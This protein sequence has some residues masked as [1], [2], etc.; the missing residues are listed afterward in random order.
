ML[1]LADIPPGLIDEAA[2]RL[3]DLL[4][5]TP[6]LPFPAWSE[7]GGGSISL[8]LETLQPIGSFKVRGALNAVAALSDAQR[9]SGVYT[10]SAGN[11][12]QALAFAAARVDST[13]AVVVPETAPAAKLDAAARLG[14]DIVSVP[15]D[16]WWDVIV[17]GRY[18]PLGLRAWV[19]PFADPRVI[20]GHG[21]IGLELIEQTPE[22]ACVYVPFGGGGL[23][24]GIALA[25]REHAPHVEV[26]ASEVDTAAAL[27]AA[28]SAGEPVDVDYRR[29]FIDGMG[30]KRVTDVMWPLLQPLV[31]GS[32]VVDVHA[33]AEAVRLLLTE[34]HLVAEGAGASSLASAL[35]DAE[36]RP[37]VC[38]V[39]GAGIDASVLARIATGADP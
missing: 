34:C 12:A 7:H 4:E 30:S 38:I 1:A 2:V 5:P 26:R 25:L 33:V 29:T 21:T 13:C 28:L 32:T 6:V 3:R 37:A 31:R 10:A 35:S 9:R 23:I 36:R 17:T 18:A 20:A 8:K 14:A 24:S 15:Y 27:A 39:S 19:H 11:M 22:M 16:E